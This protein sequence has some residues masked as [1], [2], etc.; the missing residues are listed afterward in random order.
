MKEYRIHRK[1]DWAELPEFAISEKL[2]PFSAP[3]RAYG[4]I[5]W[6]DDALHVR[7]RAV[8]PDIRAVQTGEFDMPCEDSCLEFFFCP[9]IGSKKYFNIEMN[10]NGAMFLGIGTSID[11]LARLQMQDQE[12]FGLHPMTQRTEDGWMLTYR[13][14][15]RFIR[16]FFPNFSPKPGDVLM[17]N[18]YK[19]GDECKVP[20]WLAWNPVDPT[21]RCA[22]HNPDCFGKMIFA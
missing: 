15:F 5:C 11:D 1:A 22:F 16:L 6:D 17:A 12:T 3:I 7:L 8:E 10:P 2:E 21:R 4:K 14:P 20:H 19:C 9:E 13:V 18:A